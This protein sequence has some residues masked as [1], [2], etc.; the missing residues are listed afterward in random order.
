MNPQ[1][2]DHLADFCRQQGYSAA[3]LSNPATLTWLTGYAPPI[4][5]GPNPF[6]GGP[7]LGWHRDGSL[8]LVLSDMESGAA[9]LQGVEAL[10]YVA[11]TIDAPV[12]GFAN[13]AAALK[14]A[15]AG[16]AGLKGKLGVELN[17]LPAAFL[18]LLRDALPGMS[19]S[20]MDGQLD[21]LRAVKSSEEL[22][23]IRA[24]LKLC[25][26]AQA[27][28]KR[29]I[30]PGV[31]EIEVWGQLKARLEAAAGGRL[32]LLADFVAGE[33]TAEIGGLPGGYVLQEGDAVIADIVPR[34]DG[35]WGDNAGTHFVGEP[36]PALQRIYQVVLE[37]LR[38][39]IAA[40][41]P[42]VRCC[43]LDEL[44]RSAVRA[45]GYAAY[46]HHTGHGLGV[47]YHE[48]PRI[49]PYNTLALEP[50][51]LLAL[52]PGVYVPGVG[53]VRLEDVLLVTA[54][55]CEVLTRHLGN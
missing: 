46:P 1:A 27:E 19:L 22:E 24:A 29:L 25:D 3:L 31:S 12:A 43:D 39:G 21:L 50:G 51:M 8:T 42:G 37:A 52:E 55:G 36:S 16:A 44:L 17:T 35:Y 13:Q 26:L 49:V 11:Y 5:T 20:P 4:Q 38:A 45:Q 48:E 2:L 7:A 6:E 34:L 23:R 14:G 9:R 47:A 54:H 41:K 30:R 40:V 18:E 10:E 28:T 32:P 53:G 33:R 15:L